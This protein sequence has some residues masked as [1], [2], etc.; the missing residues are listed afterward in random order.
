MPSFFKICYHQ[1]VQWCRLTDPCQ[2]IGR[3]CYLTEKQICLRLKAEK[4]LIMLY[5]AGNTNED[6]NDHYLHPSL[7]PASSSSVECVSFHFT[8]TKYNQRLYILYMILEE[9]YLTIVFIEDSA[10]CPFSKCISSLIATNTTVP[11]PQNRDH[12][13]AFPDFS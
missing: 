7:A 6:D 5:L 13:V 9:Q 10:S 12:I 2:I 1:W 11:P 8:F 4:N 3:V